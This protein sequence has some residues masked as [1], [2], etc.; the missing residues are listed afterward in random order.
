MSPKNIAGLA[1]VIMAT[2]AILA[3]GV[4][5]ITFDFGYLP[6]RIV[7]LILGH[8]KG[9]IYGANDFSYFPLLTWIIYPLLGYLFA[10]GLVR[11]KNLKGFYT[12]SGTLGLVIFLAGT[13]LVDVLFQIDNQL[14]S[15]SGYYHHQ[16]HENI[17]ATGFVMFFILLCCG[18]SKVIPSW[19]KIRLSAG[20]PM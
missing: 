14:Y 2:N 7:P 15:Y 16:A 18:L 4:G 17:I 5:I 9:L 8:L 3:Y 19:L 10:Y 1:L 13:Y 11:S 20:V 6:T 12:I